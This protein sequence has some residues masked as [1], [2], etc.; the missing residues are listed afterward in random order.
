MLQRIITKNLRKYFQLIAG[1]ITAFQR[2][3]ECP[4]NSS[5]DAG[6]KPCHWV[7]RSA[8]WNG[9]IIKRFAPIAAT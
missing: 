9:R 2:K 7:S 5:S 6:R 4:R 3:A 1:K 8:N